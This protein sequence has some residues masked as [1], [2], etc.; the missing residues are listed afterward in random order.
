MPPALPRFA[1]PQPVEL[2]TCAGCATFVAECACPVGDGARP[3]CWICAH[4]V[5]EHGVSLETVATSEACECA[6]EDI[7]PVER[8]AALRAARAREDAARVEPAKSPKPDPRRVDDVVGRR[9]R[10]SLRG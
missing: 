10:A 7:Y 6:P 4:L 9:D 8:A 1:Q 2:V 5:V 3:L